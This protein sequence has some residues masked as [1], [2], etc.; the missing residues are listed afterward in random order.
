MGSGPVVLEVGV[1]SDVGCLRAHNED[2]YL[3]GRQIWAVADGMG[4]QAAGEVASGIV[5]EQLRRADEG[6]VLSQRALVDLVAEINAA[7]LEHARKN[8]STRGLGSTVAGIASIEVGGVRHWGVFN[9]GDSRVYRFRDGVLARET[10]DH[11][12]AQHLVELGRLTPV[13]ALTHPGRSV[14]TRS[15][16]SVPAPQPDLLVLPQDRDETF[17]ICSDGLT[18]EVSD[19]VI[20]DTLRNCS[21]PTKAVDRLVDLVLA[22][23][24]RDNVTV[25]VVAVRSLDGEAGVCPEPTVPLAGSEV[26]E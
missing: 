14:L 12:E 3:V 16:G 9:V 1:R 22:H 15:L 23:G 18:S 2:S 24:A 4:G 17:L 6:G 13:D 19:A 7:I 10:V 11:N 5:V 26:D 20:S 8:P 25:I 21:D